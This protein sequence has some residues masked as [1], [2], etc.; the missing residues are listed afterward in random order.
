MDPLFNLQLLEELSRQSHLIL[1]NSGGSLRR[2]T[3][4]I[5]TLSQQ[6]DDYRLMLL[7]L[8]ETI[9]CEA[10]PLLM[11]YHDLIINLACLKLSPDTQFAENIHPLGLPIW[12]VLAFTEPSWFVD[13]ESQ[14]RRSKALT[15]LQSS[16]GEAAV[17]KRSDFWSDSRISQWASK[18]QSSLILLQGSY[19]IRDVIESTAVELIEYLQEQGQHIIWLL[20]ALPNDPNKEA[21]PWGGSS[22]LK[23]ITIQILRENASFNSLNGLAN[24]MRLFQDA[25]SVEDWFQILADTLESIP[26]IYIVINLGVLYSRISDTETWPQHFLRLFETLQKSCG[27]TL[28]VALL[29]YC[30]FSKST[31]APETPLVQITT[32][33]MSPGQ[34]L[35]SRQNF[36]GIRGDHRIHLPIFKR[37]RQL[38]VDD[39]KLEALGPQTTPVIGWVAGKSKR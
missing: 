26:Q 28:K 1:P 11:C 33:P 38:K 21:A 20:N 6:D 12:Q 2:P 16:R 15:S 22:V 37:T 31:L 5:F 19:K 25:S 32:T 29:S 13:P 23:Q 27:T 24:M 17:Q 34:T 3:D 35:I 36:S 8:E 4:V 39:S 10:T 9:S 7:K 30:P 14:K 18:D